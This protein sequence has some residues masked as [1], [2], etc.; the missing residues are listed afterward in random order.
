MMNI[1]RLEAVKKVQ[2]SAG[3]W[4]CNSYMHGMANGLILALAI[5]RGE[6]PA[7]L[8]AP[9]VWLEN[10]PRAGWP[11]VTVASLNHSY[12]VEA[13]RYRSS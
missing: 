12:A 5:A 6:E 9:D 1:E 10:I 2:C 3:N 7:F 4:N 11:A 8:A 13:Q